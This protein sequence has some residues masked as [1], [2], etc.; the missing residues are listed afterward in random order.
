MQIK[1]KGIVLKAQDYNENDKLLVIL[2]E[3]RGVLYAYA[4]GARRMKSALS[5]VSSML[6]YG[7]FVLFKNRDKYTVDSAESERLFF[8]IRKDLDSLAYASYFCE[9]CLSAANPE[10][11]AKDILRLLLNTLHILENKKAHPA[12]LKAIFELRLM[13]LIGY[14]PNLIACSEC[15]E[16]EKDAY[17]FN[18]HS[19]NA[20]CT[21]CRQNGSADDVLISKAAFLAARHIVYAPMEQ[22]FSFRI[23]ENSLIELSNAAEKYS[24]AQMDKVF[25]TLEFLN[26]IRSF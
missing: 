8:G 3:D 21:E 24:I 2:T 11:D 4:S 13:S 25:P 7:E 20:V 22:L 16:F 9:L 18:V 23:G 17:W 15:G 6:C 26:S 10:E 19:G 14:A 5:T 1:T 12:M